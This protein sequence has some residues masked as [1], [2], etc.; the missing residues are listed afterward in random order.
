[1]VEFECRF[2]DSSQDLDDYLMNLAKNL[3]KYF[4][5]RSRVLIKK[6]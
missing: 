3:R 6:V 4:R 5:R 1:M 2:V